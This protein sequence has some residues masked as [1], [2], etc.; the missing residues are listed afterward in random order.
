ML[1]RF[2]LRMPAFIQS[3]LISIF[4][5]KYRYRKVFKRPDI[6]NDYSALVELHNKKLK[7]LITNA[8]KSKYW[9]YNLRKYSVSNES[10]D[11]ISELNKIPLIS[12]VEIKNNYEDIIIQ[13]KGIINLKTSGTTG[14]GL[15]MTTTKYCEAIMWHYFSRYRE[16]FNIYENDWCGYFCGRTVKD[17]NDNHSKP[18]R[19]N[20]FGKQ[21]IFSNYHLGLDTIQEYINCLNTYQPPWIH[22]YPSF[23]TLLSGL[24]VERGLE[25]NYRP[26]GVTLGSE[27][28][29][30]HQKNSISKFFQVVPTELYCQTEGVAMISE[31]KNGKLHVDEE[32]SYVEFVEVDKKNNLYEIIGTNFHNNSFPLFR[33]RTGDM[34]KITNKKCSCGHLGRVVDSID[35]RKEEV[36]I[37]PNGA[38]IGR[39]DHIFKNMVNVTEAQ[40]IQHKDLSIVFRIVKGSLYS[41]QDEKALLVE[42]K[43]RFPDDVRYQLTYVNEIERT[44]NGKLRFVVREN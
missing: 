5:L 13:Q 9:D 7:S 3:T 37:L 33:Y 35:G 27:S 40:I 6:V 1:E 22:G 30:Q 8:E 16:R 18:W 15:K 2:Y 14:T 4:A 41:D 12:K 10:K 23:L 32:F 31:C 42:I 24:A 39:L 38:R 19:T 36:V 28:V 11:A 44:S 21:I 26:K 43:S 17:I 25:L 34:V 29:S 20:Y